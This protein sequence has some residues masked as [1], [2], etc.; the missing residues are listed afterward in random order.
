MTLQAALPTEAAS[1]RRGEVERWRLHS[2][3]IGLLRRALPATMGLIVLLLA[4]W[5]TV[6]GVQTRL[7]DARDSTALIHMSNARF[8]GRDGDG[9]AYVL[10]AAQAAR[11]D[12]D[13]QRIMLKEAMLTMNVDSPSPTRISAD[14]GVYRENDRL[15]RLAGHVTFRDATGDV[16]TTSQAVVDTVNGEVMGASKVRGQGPT[17]AISAGSFEILD[18]GQTARFS[19]EVHSRLK[20]G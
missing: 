10:S 20:Q 8:F 11:D 18:R 19:G 17:G 12:A 15:L 9:R 16:F 7:G 13:F 4:G 1:R 2:R 5:V 3:R 14:T 6:R